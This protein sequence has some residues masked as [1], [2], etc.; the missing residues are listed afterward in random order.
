[1]SR[2]AALAVMSLALIAVIAARWLDAPAAA[3][4]GIVDAGTCGGA[5]YSYT[6]EG[7]MGLAYIE[8]ADFYSVGGGAIINAVSIQLNAFVESPGAV[9]WVQNVA[10][11]AKADGGYRI[12]VADYVFNVS[13]YGSMEARGGGNVVRYTAGGRAVS[14]Y[15]SSLTVG[16]LGLPAS[17]GLMIAVNG[18]SISFYYSTGGGWRLY[19]SVEL[20]GGGLEIRV[21]P[22]EELEWVVAGPREGYTARI[23]EWSGWM[24]LLY[25]R[26]GRWYAPPCAYSGSASPITAERTSA[27]EGLAE[28]AYGDT[29]VQT[30]GRSA[31]Y[32]LWRPEISVARTAQGPAVLLTPPDGD[33]AVF[34]N[35]TR[36]GYAP[37]VL[38]PGSYNITAVLYAGSSPVYRRYI[39]V[40]S[41][42]RS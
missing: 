38:G 23:T 4:V 42:S 35:G 37:A 5:S 27:A 25:E 3:A 6:A 19:D 22:G 36:L 30:A 34:V 15:Q 39:Y 9:Y 20:P 28:Y 7:V 12:T 29:V 11:I 14:F 17:I 33:W 13:D 16:D 21:G 2:S 31:V 24:R 32:L 1:M 10:L 18:S 41:P 40:S 26:G 8:R